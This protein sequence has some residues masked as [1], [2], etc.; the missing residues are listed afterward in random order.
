MFYRFM[1][2]VI[3]LSLTIC[4]PAAGQKQDEPLTTKNRKAKKAWDEAILSLSAGNPAR[5]VPELEDAVR[6]DPSFIEA[7]L[8]LGDLHTDAGRGREAVV[9]Y[10]RAIRID[11][12]FFPNAFYLLA[13]VEFS[14]GLYADAL[15]HLRSF[16]AMGI[17]DKKKAESCDRMIASCEFALVAIEHPVPFNPVNLGKGV[18]S[19]DDEY[20][21]AVTADDQLLY[22]TRKLLKVDE[23]RGNWI[24]PEE[25]FYSSGCRGGQWEQARP[26]GPPVNTGGNE[27]ALSISPDGLRLFFA[28]CERADGFGSCDLYMAER[29]GNAWSIPEN[30]GKPVNTAAWETQPSAAGDGKTLFFASNRSGGLGG[31]DIWICTLQED[32]SWTEPVNLGNTVNTPLS[33]MN[34]FMHPDGQTL[35]FSSDGHTG[36]G[37]MD[38]FYCRLQ[39]D[40]QWSKPV[41]LGYPIN[42][43]KDEISLVVNA[44]GRV[45]YFS[46]DKLGGE[47][48]NDIYSFE[49]YGEARPVFVNYLKGRVFDKLDHRPLQAAF[50]LIDLST[51]ESVVRSRS[52]AVSGEFLVTLPAG[53]EYA[54]HVNA[55]GYLFYSD[56]FSLS[57]NHDSAQPYLKDIPL[58]PIQAGE[59]VVLNNIFFETAS[60]A[61]LPESLAELGRLLLLL[62][63]NPRLSIEIRGHTDDVGSDAYNL[64]LSSKRAEVVYGWLLEKGVPASRLN[65]KGYGESI[66]VVPNDSP[67]N[68]AK[69]RRTEFRVVSK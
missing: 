12:T 11:S 65:H 9:S 4:L 42:T 37:G 46:S 28:G 44:A 10:S 15:G 27:G 1:G 17:K 33:E 19:P 49:L 45:A 60:A 24:R 57:G 61:L 32:G 39:K 62:Q 16:K 36:L 68:R 6:H 23:S 50:E 43:W 22:F 25:D 56:H 55:D 59:I 14:Q 41:N 29:K 35:Y 38:L 67:E 3:L 30:I 66:P 51:G 34:P 63:K 69:N 8:L 31:S 52:D 54:L 47:G 40:G 58:Q 21:N 26:L 18:N 5:A 64:E 2:G 20:V 48:K 13:G 53:K 7:W